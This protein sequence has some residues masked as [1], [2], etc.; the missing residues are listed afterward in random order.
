MH[1]YTQKSDISLAK[2]SQNNMSKEH[3]KHEVIDQRKYRKRASKIKWTDR[4][5]RVQ[6]NADVAHTDVKIYCN[7]KQYP[8]L[9]FFGLHSKP[10]GASGLCKYYHL[11]FG[12]K[13]G[14]G[15]CEIFRIPCDCVAYTSMI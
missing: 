12:P 4:E 15:V 14:N 3:R 1:Y 6:D 9:L 5:Y 10:H 8:E 11:S 7:K 2:Q 13:L